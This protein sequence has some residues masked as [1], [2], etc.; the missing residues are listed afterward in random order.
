[1]CGFRSFLLLLTFFF[2][3]TTLFCTLFTALLTTGFTFS[4][5]LLITD[6]SIGILR[7]LITVLT[8]FFARYVIAIAL[9]VT[10]AII[11][12]FTAVIIATIVIISALTTVFIIL[13]LLSCG[14]SST[15]GSG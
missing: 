3:T 9:V 5:F 11:I 10:I 4:D 8:I 12:A 15:T 7:F 13:F 1:M 2:L 14:F 6:F